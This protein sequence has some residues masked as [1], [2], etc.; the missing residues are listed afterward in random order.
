MRAN[1]FTAEQFRRL[2][3][4][5]IPEYLIYGNHDP[6]DASNEYVDLPENVHEFPAG[7]P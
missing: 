2:D 3:H 5:D 6:V 7:E 1:Q 4:V